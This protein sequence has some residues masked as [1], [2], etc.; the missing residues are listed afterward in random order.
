MIH[1]GEYYPLIKA[2]G[3]QTLNISTKTNTHI[4]PFDS[5]LQYAKNDKEFEFIV[6]NMIKQA[7]AYGYEECKAWSQN[8]A[9]IRHALEEETRK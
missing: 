3:G 1:N 7:N 6:N 2:F 5:S 8:E 9:A 4:N